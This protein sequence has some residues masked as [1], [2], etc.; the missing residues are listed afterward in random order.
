MTTLY[1]CTKCHVLYAAM[2]D[3]RECSI[4]RA[5]GMASTRNPGAGNYV[6]DGEI[7]P[8]TVGITEIA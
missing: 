8:V 2:P 3:D 4:V 7:I 6:C 1:V 5:T